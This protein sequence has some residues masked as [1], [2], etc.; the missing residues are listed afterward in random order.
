MYSTYFTEWMSI[1]DISVHLN[2][3]KVVIR[4]GIE[5]L[6]S[7]DGKKW[8]NYSRNGINTV[9]SSVEMY[10][11]GIVFMGEFNRNQTCLLDYFGVGRM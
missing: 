10:P 7:C 11:N 6:R 1:I 2:I 5:R 3:L 4:I 8:Y 9:Q